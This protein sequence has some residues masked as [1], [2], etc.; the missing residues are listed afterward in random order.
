M[1]I[2]SFRYM[3]FSNEMKKHKMA[4]FLCDMKIFEFICVKI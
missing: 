3:E 2:L 1:N 4:I